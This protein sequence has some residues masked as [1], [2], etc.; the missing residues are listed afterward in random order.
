MCS[1][2]I[3]A[4][5]DIHAYAARFVEKPRFRGQT[6]SRSA[7]LTS[8]AINNLRNG[9]RFSGRLSLMEDPHVEDDRRSSEE[10]PTDRFCFACIDGRLAQHFDRR[11]KLPTGRHHDPTRDGTR[12]MRRRGSGSRTHLKGGEI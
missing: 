8:L 5:P 12:C 3:G 6:R 10:Q 4:P 2:L 1:V 11:K 9:S 7:R